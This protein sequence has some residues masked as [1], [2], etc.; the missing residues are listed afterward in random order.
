MTFCDVLG[1]VATDLL[2]ILK[3]LIKKKFFTVDDY[4]ES[5]KHHEFK[6]SENNDRPELINIAPKTT[7]LKGKAL[8]ILTHLRNVGYFMKRIIKNEAIFDEPCYQLLL[9]LYK[10][11]EYL[12]SPR[13]R[14]WEICDLQEEVLGFLILRKSLFEKYSDYFIRPRPKTH[15]LSHYP[16]AYEIYGPPVGTWTARYEV[17]YFYI[18]IPL[19]LNFCFRQSTA[20]PSLLLIAPRTLSTFQKHCWSVN[21]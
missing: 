4:N 10:I 19:C 3:V 13:M 11:V 2:A 16:A 20:R 21:K 17:K 7:K 14:L 12:M 8:S 1:V 9:K 15:Y 18:C 5:L 6:R